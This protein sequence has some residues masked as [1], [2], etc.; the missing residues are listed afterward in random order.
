LFTSP[1]M[2][3]LSAVTLLAAAL[4]AAY[5]FLIEPITVGYRATNIEIEDA[6]GQLARLERAAQQGPQLAE[7]MREYQTRRK[8]QVHFL[9]G[10]TDAL[11]A[12]ELQARIQ[13]LITEKGGTLQS[14]QSAEGVEEK[15][16][17][18][19]TLQVQMTGTMESIFAVL[20]TLEAGAPVLFI[21]NLE[22]NN[23]H[24]MPE[25]GAG[26]N[27]AELD[28]VFDVSGYLERESQL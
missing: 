27:P 8:S 14:V 16:L 9:T 5:S 11:A 24:D 26:A 25:E 19:I 13:G 4:L 22:I 28:A 20:Q 21:D 12:A 1:L 10:R 23:L 18:R 2:S 17:R 3:R 7:A 15:G 6:R